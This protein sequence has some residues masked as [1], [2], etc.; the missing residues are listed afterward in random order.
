GHWFGPHVLLACDSVLSP[1]PADVTFRYTQ[2]GA[3]LLNAGQGSESANSSSDKN[4]I[5]IGFGSMK[6]EDPESTTKITV[7]AAHL[8]GCHAIVSAGWADLGSEPGRRACCT[9]GGQ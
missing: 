9:V 3:L 6:H 1:V 2:T 5:Y 8:A 4:C 7:R